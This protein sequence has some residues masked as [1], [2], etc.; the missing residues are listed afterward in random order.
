MSYF[1]SLL[2]KTLLNT[3][4]SIKLIIKKS[5]VDFSA[6]PKPNSSS[7]AI[8]SVK[9]FQR[10]FLANLQFNV[11]RY[12]LVSVNNVGGGLGSVWIGKKGTR[13][14]IFTY[15]EEGEGRPNFLLP[16]WGRGGGIPQHPTAY[17]TDRVPNLHANFLH[18]ISPREHTE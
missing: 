1:F 14:S 4:Y 8:F 18:G 11:L 15:R 17:R 12:F 6:F 9:F 13:K 3:K 7:G 2:L 5:S 10:N 16:F